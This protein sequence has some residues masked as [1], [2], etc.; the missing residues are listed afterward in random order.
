MVLMVS[1]SSCQYDSNLH[2]SSLVLE[3]IKNPK[4]EV[5]Q[6]Q[7]TVDKALCIWRGG[8][9]K[10]DIGRAHDRVAVNKNIP[11]VILDLSEESGSIKR[12][13]KLGGGSS[14]R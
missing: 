13:C 6:L 2:R 8:L 10:R 12:V 9:G 11:M 4:N 5:K 7:A 3:C 14:T 1:S